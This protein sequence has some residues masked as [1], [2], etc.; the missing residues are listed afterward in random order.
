MDEEVD[1]SK[2]FEKDIEYIR[3]EVIAQQPNGAYTKWSRA[4]NSVSV[5]GITYNQYIDFWE[6]Q[7][8]DYPEYI[9]EIVDACMEKLDNGL[10]PRQQMIEMIRNS[11]DFESEKSRAIEALG[12]EYNEWRE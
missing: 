10:I 9:R 4:L 1:V 5:V 12:G 3:N 2:R 6:R 8:K 11:K 7:Y